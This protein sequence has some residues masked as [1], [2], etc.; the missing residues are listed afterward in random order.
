MDKN[1][2]TFP[3]SAG[4]YVLYERRLKQLIAHSE[5]IQIQAKRG[6]LPKQ[7]PAIDEKIKFFEKTKLY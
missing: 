1:L 7:E 2:E 6:I 4:L 3:I 5:A